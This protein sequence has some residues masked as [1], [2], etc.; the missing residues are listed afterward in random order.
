MQSVCIPRTCKSSRVETSH[1]AS[2][3]CLT[4]RSL[5][6][7]QG[8]HEEI[9]EFAKKYGAD[10]KFVWFEKGDV[11]G[12]KTREVYSF[13]KPILPNPDET[14]DIT[15]NFATFLVDHEGKPVRRFLPTKKVYE[16]LKPKIE[17]LVE[18]ASK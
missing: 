13:L 10:E 17:G 9:L 2:S 6:L 5:S 15:W 11:N 16:L 1:G 8:T 12:S 7:S 4:C 3:L 14:T 18:A